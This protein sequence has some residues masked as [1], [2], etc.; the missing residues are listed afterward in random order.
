MEISISESEIINKALDILE[1]KLHYGESVVFNS[2]E[3]A[4]NYCKLKLRSLK[5]EHFAVL[6][7]DKRH[8]LIE[9]SELFHG[10]IDCSSVHPRVVAQ[11]ALEVNAAAV[12]FA[13]NHPSGFAE[14]SHADQQITNQ[15]KNALSMFDVRVLD[16][17]VVGEDVVSFAERRLI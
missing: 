11:K 12:I 5:N 4:K 13:H 1:E 9:Y 17:L 7:L 16:H 14:P 15:L 2:S 6:F 3:I 10:T 8:R